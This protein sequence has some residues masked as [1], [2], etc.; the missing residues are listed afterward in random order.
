MIVRTLT[1]SGGYDSRS[2]NRAKGLT[3]SDQAIDISHSFT[4][5]DLAPYFE[6]L[7]LSES[8]QD[9]DQTR[10]FLKANNVP[11]GEANPLVGSNPSLARLTAIGAAMDALQYAGYKAIP[12]PYKMPYTALSAFIEGT[13]IER[14]RKLTGYQ[15]NTGL[16]ALGSIITFFLTKDWNANHK[17]SPLKVE[18]YA[19]KTNSGTPVQGVTMK[20]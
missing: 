19:A 8:L 2:R 16:A 6:G 7:T 20:W 11:G 12:A 5:S 15:Y 14:N 9:W 17:D 10:K 1:P 3:M 13:N 18:P 4:L